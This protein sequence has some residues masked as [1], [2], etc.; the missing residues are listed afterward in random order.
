MKPTVRYEPRKEIIIHEYTKYDSPDEFI[1][2]L[3][4]GIPAG[5]IA[6]LRWVDGVL[7][8]FNAFPSDS[9]TTKENLEGRIHWNHVNFALLPEYKEKII[10]KSGVTVIIGN[11]SKNPS[12]QAVAEF[13]KENFYK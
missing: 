9:V 3:V 6:Q 5:S 10:T 2:S 4:L 1:E 12:F 11:V 8:S 13:I 7:L